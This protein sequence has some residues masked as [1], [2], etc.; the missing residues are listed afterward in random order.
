MIKIIFLSICLFNISISFASCIPEK[1]NDLRKS[2]L[3][4]YKAKDY[5]SAEKTL[6]QYYRNE[7]SIFDMVKESDVILNKGL[8]LI[9]DL[10]FYHQKQGNL[11][12][13]LSLNNEIYDIWMVSEP[14][15]YGEK[16]NKALKANYNQCKKT[17]DSTYSKANKCPIVGYEHML[18][19]PESWR[20]Q[21][22]QYYEIPCLSFVENSE[23]PAAQRDGPK[24]ASE[25]L[26]GIAQLDIL[27]TE[28][29][30]R[31]TPIYKLDR[32]YFITKHDALFGERDCYNLTPFFGK[33]SGLIYF[34]GYASS[35]G[36]GSR[37]S[38]TRLLVKLNFP[39]EARIVNS[40]SLTVK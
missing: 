21:D 3:T 31:D 27:Y 6:T 16:V 33:K 18:A 15:R 35:C 28:K 5:I 12:E 4:S 9:S 11:L 8:W 13:C 32:L 39:F 23:T 10:M 29:V 7:C 22:E 19:L 20:N 25:G 24:T 36:I 14:S 1:I 2:A 38:I 37:T 34:D 30:E 26:N 17:L 40:T